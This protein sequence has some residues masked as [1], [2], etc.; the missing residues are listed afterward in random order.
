MN[1]KFQ[2]KK[3]RLLSDVGCQKS[4]D[5]IIKY[6]ISRYFREQI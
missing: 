2:V 4:K 1:Q 3:G 5:N 6:V